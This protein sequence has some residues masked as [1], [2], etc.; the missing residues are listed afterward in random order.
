M[1]T[2]ISQHDLFF[3]SVPEQAP[4]SFEIDI[5]RF[6]FAEGFADLCEVQSLFFLALCEVLELLFFRQ[7]NEEKDRKNASNTDVGFG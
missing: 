2:Q 6:N 4:R 7:I 5:Y 1:C 3:S